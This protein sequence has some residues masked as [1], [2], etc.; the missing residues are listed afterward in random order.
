MPYDK[1]TDTY[2]WNVEKSIDYNYFLQNRVTPTNNQFMISNI[3]FNTAK[4]K[5]QL[6]KDIL[7]KSNIAIWDMYESCVRETE[8]GKESSLDEHI[9]KEVWNDIPEL[10]NRYPNIQWI[11]IAGEKNYNRFKNHFSNI[12]LFV[13]QVPSTSNSSPSCGDDIT[14]P[15]WRDWNAL[16]N[17][18]NKE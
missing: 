12:E 17:S 8:E 4:E 9:K 11:G 16:L 18:I 1:N 14:M 2:K 15:V 13:F 3:I 6:S 7:E 10:L 5:V